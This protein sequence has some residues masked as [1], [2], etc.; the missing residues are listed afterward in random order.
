MTALKRRRLLLKSFIITFVF[1]ALAIAGFFLLVAPLAD[2]KL[3]I[4]S[5]ANSAPPSEKAL[6]LHQ[7]LVIVDLHADSL[8]WDRDPL[9]RATPAVTSMYRG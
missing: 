5:E 8:L 6:R 1:L 7:T 4:V 2:R 3:N 9:T